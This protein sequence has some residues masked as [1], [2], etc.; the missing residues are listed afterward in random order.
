MNT[1]PITSRLRRVV[2]RVVL[3]AVLLSLLPV[4]LWRFADPPVTLLMVQRWLAAPQGARLHHEWVDLDEVSPSFLL[5]VVAAEDQ[6]FPHHRGFDLDSIADALETAAEGGQL[7]GASTIS[8]QVAKNVFLWPERSW[9]R[10]GLEAYYTALIELAWGK[11]RILEVYVNVAEMGPLVFGVEAA[12][13]HWYGIPASGLD[14]ERAALLAAVLPSPLARSP[15]DPSP[16]V[17][18]RQAWILRQMD[19]LGPA[20]LDGIRAA[21]PERGVLRQSGLS[22]GSTRGAG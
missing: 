21:R 5:A 22:T 18:D 6:K 19:N 1:R 2:L 16:G 8:Q 13:R 4:A 9:V 12:S 10:K 3:G 14:A 11:R 20:W 17:R 7:R 15:V